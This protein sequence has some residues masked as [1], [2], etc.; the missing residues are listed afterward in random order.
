MDNRALGGK[1][2][3]DTMS[4]RCNGP[5]CNTEASTVK[6]RLADSQN[7][8][9]APPGDTLSKDLSSPAPATNSAQ[10]PIAGLPSNETA[11]GQQPPDPDGAPKG[12]PGEGSSGA[13]RKTSKADEVRMN[14]WVEDRLFEL[15]FGLH[16]GEFRSVRTLSPPLAL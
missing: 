3:S 4:D 16:I 14:D 15:V 5:A 7:P 2:N 9:T 10:G 12:V 8:V 1:Q 6:K 13:P 11:T